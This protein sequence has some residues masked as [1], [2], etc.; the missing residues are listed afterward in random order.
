MG[1][2]TVLKYAAVSIEGGPVSAFLGDYMGL[3][4]SGTTFVPF[5]GMAQPIA[6][7]GKTDIFSNRAG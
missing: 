7:T 5:F 1:P 4:A 3:A 6:T 2:P